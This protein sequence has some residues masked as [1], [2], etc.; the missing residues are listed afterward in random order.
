MVTIHIREYEQYSNNRYYCKKNGK[1]LCLTY[2]QWK[3]LVEN[4]SFMD[5]DVVAL[6]KEV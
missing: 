3:T 4:I 5:K 2:P 6:E 1:G